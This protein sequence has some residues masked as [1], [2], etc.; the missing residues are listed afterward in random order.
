MELIIIDSFKHKRVFNNPSFTPRIGEKIR[1]YY[2][3]SPKVKEVI[4]DIDKNKVYVIL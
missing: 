3:P 4:Y 1:W 2:Y